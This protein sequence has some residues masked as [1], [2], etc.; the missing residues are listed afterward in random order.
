MNGPV[1]AGFFSFDY[2]RFIS[3]TEEDEMLSFFR[4][5]GLVLLALFAVS[6]A[7]AKQVHIGGTHSRSDIAKK[8]SDV[9]GQPTN[10]TGKSGPY[11]CVNFNKSTSVNCDSHG[12]CT[13]TV[14][15]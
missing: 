14:P 12:H 9:G 2:R 4:I 13:G 8:C 7:S 6:E 5:F 15:D 1:S 10:T 3:R 11:G